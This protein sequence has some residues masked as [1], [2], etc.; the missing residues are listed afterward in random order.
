[1]TSAP[2]ARPGWCAPDELGSGLETAASSGSGLGSAVLRFLRSLPRRSMT[3]GTLTVALET[4][5]AAWDAFVRAHPSATA[6]HSWAWRDVFG[7]VFGHE[8]LYLAAR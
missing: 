3:D 5:G 2:R 6:Y 8:P 4:D 7:G 1:S